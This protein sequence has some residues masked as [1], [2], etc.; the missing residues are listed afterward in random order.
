M[1]ANLKAIGINVQIKQFERATQ[2]TKEST[3]TEP[4]DIADEGWIADYPDPFDWVN[5]L[6]NGE[7]IPATNGSNYAYFNNPEFNK[8]MDDAAKLSGQE[9]FTTYGNIA[10]AIMQQQAPWAAW[11]VDN[12]IDFFSP[13]IGCTVYNPVYGMALNT[14][15]VK[16]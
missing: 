7:H 8:Q 12:N 2:F 10:T 3:K 4:F 6:L 1:Q 11:D 16:S 9:R 14:M 13:R 15:C 5:V